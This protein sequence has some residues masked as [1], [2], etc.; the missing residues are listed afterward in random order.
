MKKLVKDLRTGDHVWV[1]ERDLSIIECV[2]HIEWC[3]DWHSLDGYVS[4]KF[5]GTLYTGKNKFHCT[6]S[7][8]QVFRCGTVDTVDPNTKIL[9]KEF[10]DRRPC[11]PGS[12]FPDE[13]ERWMN[14]TMFFNVDIHVFTN[15][16]DARDFVLDCKLKDIRAE[17]AKTIKV[18]HYK[19]KKS[20]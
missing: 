16:E 11:V 3:D 15:E 19:P 6:G 5:I 7:D 9:D 12:V 14:S 4:K 13:Y 18:K 17:L 2:I 8:F 1:V 10:Y 20:L